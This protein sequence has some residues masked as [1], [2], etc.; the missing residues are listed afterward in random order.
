[1]KLHFLKYDALASL[2]ANVEGNLEKYLLPTNDWIY[3][4]FGEE[5]PFGEFMTTVGDISF[6]YAEKEQGKAD[7]QNVIT[8]YSAMMN[9][10]DTQA[11]DERLW[12]GMCHGDM[13]EFANKQIGRAHV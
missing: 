3:E 6:V 8:L 4:F 2:R 9:I 5:D 1:M 7:V 11:S 12:A 10:T 13:W